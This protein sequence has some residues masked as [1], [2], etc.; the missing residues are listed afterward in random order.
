MTFNTYVATTLIAAL[1][2]GPASSQL[3]PA[4]PAPGPACLS[5]IA[6]VDPR[7]SL[8]ITEVEVVEQAFSLEEVLDQLARD[9]GVPG[10]T[11]QDLWVQ[12]GILHPEHPPLCPRVYPT[13]LIL[14]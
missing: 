14:F 2:A 13:P 12:C 8:F 6:D 5:P 3:L 9:S 10:L 1:L 7:R 4:L 11:A